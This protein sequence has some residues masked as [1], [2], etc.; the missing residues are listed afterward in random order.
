MKSKVMNIAVA[1][2]E[3]KDGDKSYNLSVISKLAKKSE[4]QGC[5]AD[6]FPRNV[7]A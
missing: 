4:I 5:R 6:K 7:S 3:P 1:Q 2:F